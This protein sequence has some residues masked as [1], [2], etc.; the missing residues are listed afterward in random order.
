M[1][2]GRNQLPIDIVIA[3]I[4][5][6]QKQIESLASKPYSINIDVKG[7]NFTAPLGKIKGQLGEFEKSLEASNARVIAFGASASAIY[8]VEKALSESVKAAIEVEKAL[9]DINVI[10]NLSSKSLNEFGTNLFNIAKNTGNTF[11]TVAAAA[12]ELSRQGLGVT[13]TLKRTQDA[14]I[15]TRLSGLG[16]AESVNAIT[17][18]LNGFQKAA[19]SSTDIIN[20]L[21]AVD[22]NFA[23]SSGDLAEAIKRVG[24]SAEDAGVSFDQLL[25]IVTSAQQ[26]TARGGA[27]IGNS[28]KTIFTRL[29]RPKV[30]DAL[31]QLGIETQTLAGNTRPVID[32]LTELANKY[33]TLNDRQKSSIAE[34]VGGVFQINILKA[35]LGDLSKEYSIYSQALSISSGASNEAIKRNEQLNTTLAATL[36]KTLANLT[37]AGAKIGELSLA[38]ALKKV[39]GGLNTAL[40]SFTGGDSE[41]V[42]NKIGEGLLRGLGNFLS[43]PGLIVGARALFTIFE[44]LTTFS[45]DAIKTLLGLNTHAAEQLQIQEQITTLL[46]KNPEIITQ[47]A[48]GQT[49]VEAVQLSILN[50]IKAQTL[51]MQ[52]QVTLAKSLA[53]SLSAAGV[54]IGKTGAGKGTLQARSGGFI[55]NL[56]GE[57]EQNARSMGAVNPRAQISQG[58][59]GGKKFIKNNK[60]IEIVGAGRNGDSA[61][62]PTYGSIGDKRQ[63]EY[64][65]KLK[66]LGFVPNFAKSNQEKMQKNIYAAYRKINPAMLIAEGDQSV[67]TLKYKDATL[68]YPIIPLSKAGVESEKSIYQQF[69]SKEAIDK[70]SRMVLDGATNYINSI[71]YKPPAKQISTDSLVGLFSKNSKYKGAYGALQAF[72][73]AAFEVGTG[74]ALGVSAAASDGGDFDVRNSSNI[75]KVRKYFPGNYNVADFKV[76]GSK[77]NRGSM[78]D[79]IKKDLDKLLPN[80]DIIRQ[81]EKEAIKG[82]SLSSAKKTLQEYR[83]NLLVG[84]QRTITARNPSG[85]SPLD[86]LIAAKKAKGFIPNFAVFNA[87]KHIQRGG[88]VGRSNKSTAQGLSNLISLMGMNYS[89]PITKQ[90]LT[91]LFSSKENKKKLYQFLKKQPI[92]I[93]QYPELYSEVKDGNHRFELAQLAGIK[94][95]PVE[96]LAKG[97]IPNFASIKD[98]M[99]TEKKM[100]GNPALDFQE[101][102]GLYVRDKNTQSNFSAVKRDHPEGIN[103]AIKNSKMAQETLARGFIPNFAPSGGAAA[104]ASAAS[105]SKA[106]KGLQA[107]MLAASFAFS[108]LQGVVETFNRDGKSAFGNIISGISQGASTFSSIATVIPGQVG[109]VIGAI[110]G[111]VQA[112]DSI[113]DSF[114]AAALSDIIKNGE[115]AAEGLNKLSDASQAY[116]QAFEKLTEITSNSASSAQ[117]IIKAQQKLQEALLDLPNQYREQYAS[118]KNLTEMQDIMG[119]ALAAKRKEAMQK[120]SAAD[121]AKDVEKQGKTR[122]FIGDFVRDMNDKLGLTGKST[123][124]AKA[125]AAGGALST[126]APLVALAELSVNFGKDKVQGKKDKGIFTGSQF[127]EQL[128][129][130]RASDIFKGLD[131][132][133]AKDLASGVIKA[134]QSG[135]QWLATLK[136]YGA[137]ADQLVSAQAILNNESADGVADFKMLTDALVNVAKTTT[138][139]NDKLNKLSEEQ[140]KRLADE[141]QKIINTRKQIEAEKAAAEAIEIRTA[142]TLKASMEEKKLATYRQ[143]SMN[144]IATEAEKSR[145][146]T[147][148]PFITEESMARGNAQVTANQANNDYGIKVQES[149]NKAIEEM[150]NQLTTSIDN[151]IEELKKSEGRGGEAVTKEIEKL[152]GARGQIS[153]IIKSGGTADQ[154]S[155]KFQELAGEGN[156]ELPD[157][158][159]LAVQNGVIIQ[160]ARAEAAKAEVDRQEQIQIAKDQLKAQLQQLRDQKLLK[161]G[162]GIQGFLNPETLKDPLEKFTQGLEG[163]QAGRKTGLGMMEARGSLQAGMSL[164]E[165]TGGLGSDKLNKSLRD[166]VVPAMAAQKKQMFNDIAS[167][168]E[169]AGN[170]D[171]AQIA[172]DAAAEAESMAQKQFDNQFKLEDYVA[173]INTNVAALAK[174]GVESQTTGGIQQGIDQA[175]TTMNKQT[176]ATSIAT[177]PTSTVTNAT[178]AEGNRQYYPDGTP[179]PTKEERYKMVHAPTMTKEQQIEM[180]KRKE[181]ES[182]DLEQQFRTGIFPKDTIANEYKEPKPKPLSNSEL[183]KKFAE[184]ATNEVTPF[185]YRDQ[186]FKTE[187]DLERYK[188][189]AQGGF[190]PVADAYAEKQAKKKNNVANI[191]AGPSSATPITAGTYAANVSGNSNTGN[192]LTT[193]QV[194]NSIKQNNAAQEEILKKR[195]ALAG[196][197]DP[198]SN[199][200]RTQLDKNLNTLRDQQKAAGTAGKEAGMRERPAQEIERQQKGRPLSSNQNDQGQGDKSQKLADAID[201]NTKATTESKS[202][203][204]V[205]FTPISVEVKGSIETASDQLSQK[206]MDAIQKAVEQL[207]PGIMAKLKGPP[208]RES[209]ASNTVTG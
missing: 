150:T 55:P 207:A 59:I 184:G 203:V 194:N 189:S 15:L 20:K 26:I 30:L 193:P 56:F 90:N 14:L 96:Y 134:D 130:E 12:T 145:L 63:K 121:L 97:F 122:N 165:L 3:N 13:E 163:M 65:D 112:I 157:L 16:A 84:D 42:G 94:N 172:R 113:K 88:F 72:I 135:E 126:F 161:G 119:Q 45:A 4:R 9:V 147:K 188:S 36:N 116:A 136:R 7:K 137:S 175:S 201:K 198:E 102:I 29:E 87:N 114:K 197:N 186:F 99:E 190:D 37:A 75:A 146:Q 35:A 39:M 183:V 149:N 91:Q 28:F 110:V 66:F 209:G 202:E 124:G 83:Q 151:Q 101:G 109:L 129:T 10:L 82:K 100:G 187:K 166:K 170:K 196:K 200:Q 80:L 22:A 86:K 141:E 50:T 57:E 18:S 61:V 191:G 182:A 62:I 111:V 79:K 11:S 185:L 93:K 25:A 192:N 17:A 123:K 144:R 78:S 89:G 105:S 168:A 92:L 127:G 138:K 21:A 74:E 177:N 206:T 179:I 8:A 95:I 152:K 54:S 19:L 181:K 142:A 107:K 140:K 118:A 180:N 73:G 199:R 169:G 125:T 32:I 81:G 120:Q 133:F 205:A 51:A 6:A 158:Q 106:M 174:G 195:D 128:A 98:A 204:N 70:I 139:A 154:V 76:S 38:P 159:K 178:P 208:T 176:V 5:A 23:V 143:S 68:Q 48:S 33:D 156:L 27:V 167:Q 2:Q 60:E 49:T 162:G 67:G 34:Q 117:D 24:S 115:L 41:D 58:T 43:G 1:A 108:T 64:Y 47:I 132:Q 40:E 77:T 71:G 164:Q 103:N 104:A 171:L 69:N 31:Q 44:R 148:Q 173:E 131:P 46:S 85:T 153:N 53:A 155:N 52:Q 160:D